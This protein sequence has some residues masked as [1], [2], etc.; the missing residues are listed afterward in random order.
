[1]GAG[2]R[3]DGLAVVHEA[4]RAGMG[5][6]LEEEC[7]FLKKRRGS[8]KTPSWLL[9]RLSSD[10]DSCLVLSVSLVYVLICGVWRC[11]GSFFGQQS[12]LGADLPLRLRGNSLA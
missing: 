10:A 3:V 7:S 12:P 5:C 8:C 9:L 11:F 1:M 4:V 6:A 2:G